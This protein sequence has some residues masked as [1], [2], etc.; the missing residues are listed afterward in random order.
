MFEN[1]EVICQHQYNG[2]IIPLYVIWH[3]GVKYKID[4]I[5]QKCPSIHHSN[6]GIGIRYTCVIH[7]QR[8][9][10]HAIKNKW[11]IEKV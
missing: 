3:N 8:R 10:L 1:I 2:E 9:Y 6:G 5:T 11:F 4:R 7:N